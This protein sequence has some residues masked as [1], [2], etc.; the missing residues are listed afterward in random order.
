MTSMVPAKVKN[1]FAKHVLALSMVAG[2]AAMALPQHAEASGRTIYKDRYGLVVQACQLMPY[3]NSFM[4]EAY[5]RVTESRRLVDGI[6]IRDTSIRHPFWTIKLPYMDTIFRG[7]QAFRRYGRLSGRGNSDWPVNSRAVSIALSYSWQ[8][9]TRDGIR[10]R[11]VRASME[12]FV[13]RRLPVC[14]R[15]VSR[16]AD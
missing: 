6:W 5:E 1:S 15:G 8:F 16:Y 10:Y 4:L 9:S 3:S 12:K 2:T 7:G 13:P 14:I 11:P